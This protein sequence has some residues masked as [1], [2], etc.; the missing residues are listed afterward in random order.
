MDYQ[1]KNS[2][3]CGTQAEKYSILLQVW[4]TVIFDFVLQPNKVG[5]Q[6]NLQPELQPERTSC[7]VH[8]FIH[9]VASKANG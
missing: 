2:V 9:L 1:V 4:K 6:G 5:N 7:T 3:K 8:S